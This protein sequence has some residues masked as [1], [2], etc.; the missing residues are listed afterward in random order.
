MQSLQDYLQHQ[1]EHQFRQQFQ[2]WVIQN[3]QQSP[4]QT[5]KFLLNVTN[6][7]INSNV[8]LQLAYPF[9]DMF[10][11]IYPEQLQQHL[12]ALQSLAADKMH[13]FVA[14]SYALRICPSEQLIAERLS[15]KI[16]AIR[17]LALESF[18]DYLSENNQLIFA[19]S[20]QTMSEA[21]QIQIVQLLSNNQKQLMMVQK[22]LQQ[23]LLKIPYSQSLFTVFTLDQMFLKAHVQNLNIYQDLLEHLVQNTVSVDS[24]LD[25]INRSVFYVPCAANS[26]QQ[27]VFSNNLH[28]IVHNLEQ[29]DQAMFRSYV[30]TSVKITSKIT[31]AHLLLLDL[32]VSLIKKILQQLKKELNPP[33]LQILI[34]K[35]TPDI[36]EELALFYVQN[37]HS[38][39]PSYQQLFAQ[40]LNEENCSE[41]AATI[42]N[43]FTVLQ[44]TD[45]SVNFVCQLL[46]AGSGLVSN[47]NVN[48]LQAVLQIR[49]QLG[50]LTSSL[51]TQFFN[52]E[53]QLK[54][55][56]KR[57]LFKQVIIALGAVLSSPG[58][59]DFQLENIEAW[60]QQLIENCDATVDNCFRS[61]VYVKTNQF[62]QVNTEIMQLFLY[63]ACDL[64]HLLAQFRVNTEQMQRLF[65]KKL[66]VMTQ[67]L[68]QSQTLNNAVKGFDV[69][70]SILVALKKMLNL[71][72][73]GSDTTCQIGCAFGT[74]A[75]FF[76]QNS[77]K[78]MFAVLKE[79][80]F[81]QQKQFLTGL[82]CGSQT[83]R[84]KDEDDSQCLDM[85]VEMIIDGESDNKALWIE[86]LSLFVLGNCKDD[87]DAK[88][89]TQIVK[90]IKE[91]KNGALAAY[92]IKKCGFKADQF[93]FT[94]EIDKENIGQWNY[95]CGIAQE[96]VQ[97]E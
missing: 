23:I 94:T 25:Y 62:K 19:Q 68:G 53:I 72:A 26:A 77:Q 90:Y 97:A 74:I 22:Q 63:C 14:F 20:L 29:V 33:L 73:N 78:S 36:S 51:F 44:V 15:D 48:Q 70:Q 88:C 85:F 65:L 84:F 64:L 12:Q 58:F 86:F 37:F 50:Q 18:V 66:V 91:S 76:S 67:Q 75:R 24:F 95:F 83:Y 30:A 27:H 28:N 13:R 42:T 60:C 46:A 32:D 79:L 82:V 89:E 40:L 87:L 17:K 81:I 93:D 38:L 49:S 39:H 21:H 55:E 59:K 47:A 34:L 8:P 41:F 11:K 45:E 10:N 9:L 56:N 80:D 43:S 4:E 35:C 1:N 3:H 52:N 31:P 61:L 16:V 2:P 69:T 54:E 71:A 92:L 5:F 7:F 6:H 96:F 57:E